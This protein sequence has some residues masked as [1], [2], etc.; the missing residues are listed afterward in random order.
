VFTLLKDALDAD[1][2][3]K[4]LLC[5]LRVARRINSKEFLAKILNSMWA[6][7]IIAI[8]REVQQGLVIDCDMTVFE[9]LGARF[10]QLDMSGKDLQETAPLFR[11]SET[12]GDA[13]AQS[14]DL[15]FGYEL[16]DLV[17]RVLSIGVGRRRKEHGFR[18]MHLHVRS[19]NGGPYN[20]LCSA[21]G[22]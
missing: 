7:Q 2:I 9:G 21:D 15:G 20:G 8:V 13:W 10:K 4:S 11:V 14:R 19:S 17:G 1:G 5:S 22:G 12:G 3:L 6:L 16:G 18:G